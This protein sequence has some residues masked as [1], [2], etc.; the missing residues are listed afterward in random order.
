MHQ[1]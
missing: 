1:W